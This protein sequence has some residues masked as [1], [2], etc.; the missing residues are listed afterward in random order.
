MP[1]MDEFREERATIKNAT[2]KQKLAYFWDYYKW[3]VIIICFVLIFVISYVYNLV[4]EKDDAFYA[5]FLNCYTTE[6]LEA[7]FLEDFAADA[8]IDTDKYEVLVDTSLTLT[9][10]A[11]DENSYMTVQ[12]MAVYM[13][14]QEIDVLAADTEAFYRYA[15]NDG[16][17]DLRDVLTPEQQAMYEPYYFYIDR[18]VA[19]AQAEAAE[20]LET[21]N[22]E[23]P[24]P[25]NPEAM[26][27]PVPVGL[28]LE[29]TD[30]LD[31]YYQF[32]GEGAAI[33]IIGNAPRL[34]TAI[35]FL[36][37]LFAAE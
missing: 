20:N 23:Y 2:P 24:D 13:A 29:Y 30:K 7:P 18:A 32:V 5:V 10:N 19:Q 4:T 36:N 31:G 37:Y 35:G 1:V 15:Y 3:P 22:A 17:Y 33:G 8:G 11:T 27:D 26:E 14:A 25:T 21:F 16:L 6:E 12:K 9:A 34:E 28:F